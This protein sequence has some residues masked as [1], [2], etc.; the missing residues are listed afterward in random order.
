[1]GIMMNDAKSVMVAKFNL[2]LILCV[3]AT[4]PTCATS[5]SS[6]WLTIFTYT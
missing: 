6:V 4:E 2:F 1:M 5:V 3:L